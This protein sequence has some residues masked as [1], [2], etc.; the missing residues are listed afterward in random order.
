VAVEP[1]EVLTFWLGVRDDEPP[2][3]SDVARWFQADPVLDAS[4]RA[5]FGDRVEE[6]LG[7]GLEAWA[8]APR[9]RVALVILLD[10]FPRNLHRGDP[11]SFEGDARALALVRRT[12]PDEFRALHPLEHYFLLVPW[13]HAE[14]LEA[15]RSGE[16]GFAH[17]RDAVPAAFRPLFETGLEFAARHRRV[18]ERFGRF[19]HRNPILGRTS[20]PEEE[21]F[22]AEHPTGF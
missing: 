9:E 17:A 1:R 19:P 15:Q 20:T 12:T 21:A 8:E 5:R 14:D 7:G 6:A 11:R 22:L 13:M 18:I 10:Q 3:E 2:G 4:I 16:S